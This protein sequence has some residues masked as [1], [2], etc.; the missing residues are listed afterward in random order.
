MAVFLIEVNQ[1]GEH[2]AAIGTILQRLATDLHQ[3]LQPAG[4]AAVGDALHGEDVADLADADD[5]ATAR[6]QHIEQCRG[7]RWCGVVVPVGRALEA[8]RAAADK[9]PRDD[10]TD[11]IGINQRARHLTQCVQTLQPERG[12][13]RGDLQ[14]RI[15]RG[16]DNRPTAAQV[17]FAELRDDLGARRMAIAEHAFG[18]GGLRDGL[19]EFGRKTLATRFEIAP[20]EIDRQAAELPMP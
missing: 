9:G 20:V 11:A 18:A 2:Q 16:V 3:R 13:V 12:F 10:P 15:G 19:Q 4:L 6:F 14:H 1:I 8:R 7:S 5:I 17:L